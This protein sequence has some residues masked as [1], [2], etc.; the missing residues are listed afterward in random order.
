M[1]RSGQTLAAK[2]WIFVGERFPLGAHGP[3]VLLFALGNFSMAARLAGVVFA[4]WA[5]AASVLLSLSF[6]FRLRCFDEIKDYAVDVAVNP[7][8]PLARGLLQA[9]QVK[10]MLAALILFELGLAA[11]LGVRV[12]CV[13][14]LAMIYSFL[15]YREFFIGRWLRPH[16]TTYALT[17]TLVSVL[18]GL[19]VAT[20]AT[21]AGPL[22]WSKALL[23]FVFINWFMF[24]L[25]E[26][27]R[28]T[29]ATSEERP[30]VESYSS[31]FGTYAAVA[32]SLLQVGLSLGVL[33]LV[34]LQA[35]ALV[36]PLPR[37]GGP[38][39]LL[40]ALIP[41]GAAVGFAVRKSESAARC[42]RAVVSGYLLICYTYLSWLG[43]AS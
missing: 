42:F 31:L 43:F 24:N 29:F 36:R 5:F 9:S 11:W 30:A 1:S 25:F 6:F 10:R 22:P 41:L 27:A 14:G 16:L 19:S 40:L 13:H 33:W 7:T 18:L 32:L 4:P 21:L 35:D 3:M 12:L 17:H 2:W 20:Q 28:K 23:T 37:W 34:S 39:A 15:M 8:R 38:V 26:F